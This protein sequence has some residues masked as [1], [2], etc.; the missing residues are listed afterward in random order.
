MENLLE[1]M[2]ISPKEA[3]AYAKMEEHFQQYITGGLVPYREMVNELGRS[4]RNV[5]QLK[6][7]VEQARA[8]A[9]KY[10]NQGLLGAARKVKKV[11]TGWKRE[12]GN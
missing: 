3:A 7:D 4:Y 8:L 1:V 5:E 12:E 6:E 2:G 10:K 11:I 9:E